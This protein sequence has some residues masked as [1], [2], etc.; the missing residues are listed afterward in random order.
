VL[1][2]LPFFQNVKTSPDP[3]DPTVTSYGDHSKFIT[4]PYKNFLTPTQSGSFNICDYIKIPNFDFVT[5]TGKDI[6]QGSFL[7]RLAICLFTTMIVSMLTLKMYDGFATVAVGI[8]GGGGVMLAGIRAAPLQKEI[9][10]IVT[11]VGGGLAKSFG[12][13]RAT[14]NSSFTSMVK[15]AK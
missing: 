12:E 4:G 14:M 15:A 8:F 6:T 11:N 2:D 9:T 7:I 5:A 3:A 13:V 10:G 1:K